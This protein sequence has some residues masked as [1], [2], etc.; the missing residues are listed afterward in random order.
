M[1]SKKIFF[2]L[3]YFFSFTTT[4]DASIRAVATTPDIAWLIHRIGAE[5]VE[6]KTLSKSG[7]NYHYLEARPDFILSV[8]RGDIVCRIGIDLEIGWLPK[9][10]EKAANPKVMP[11]GIGDCDLSRTVQI[12]EKPTTPVDRSMG[13]VHAAGNPHFWL[14]PK[15]MSNAAREVEI[16]LAAIAPEKIN[17]FSKNRDQL[18]QELKELEIKIQIKLKNIKGKSAYQY[19]KDFSYFFSSYGIHSLGSIEEIP[20]VSPSAARLGKI[21]LEAKA[22]KAAF[23][24]A[25]E[26]DPKSS[27]EK[28]R[29]VSNT[30]VVI[31]PS[32]LKNPADAG[33]YAKWQETLAE[34]L[35]KAIP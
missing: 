6:V 20:G 21:S 35:I 8:N 34:A 19:H 17:I 22:K 10:L 14:S 2:F 31:V 16:R 12:Q 5:H 1:I 33:A 11:G 3:V 23:A 13:D 9:V 29:E 4:V 26:H 25:S 24:I 7:D 18:E 28:F 15:E 27:L 30:P 32:S